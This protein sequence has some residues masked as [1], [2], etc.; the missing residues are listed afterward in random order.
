MDGENENYD[1]LMG[2]DIDHSH[3]EVEADTLAWGKWVLEEVITSY[4]VNQ[5]SN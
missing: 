3:P 1:Y 4:I 2:A 5:R